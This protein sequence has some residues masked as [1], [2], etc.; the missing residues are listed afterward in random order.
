MKVNITVFLVFLISFLFYYCYIRPKHTTD[1]HID[2][3]AFEA[4]PLVI[5]GKLLYQEWA[6]ASLYSQFVVVEKVL[7]NELKEEIKDTLRVSIEMTCPRILQKDTSEVIYLQRYEIIDG[8]AFCNFYKNR[9]PFNAGKCGY[10][11]QK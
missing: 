10:E 4:V 5:E 9:H 11:E 2:L 3:L 8:I 7:K 6:F 1:K